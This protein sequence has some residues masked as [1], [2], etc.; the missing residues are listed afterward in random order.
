M[1]KIM[2]SNAK[3]EFLR[4]HVGQQRYPIQLC[5]SPLEIINIGS[6]GNPLIP[7]T[8]KHA[9]RPFYSL[10]SKIGTMLCGPFTR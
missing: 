2:H 8:K 5:R 9:L 4:K 7:D 6:M 10:N 1:F 3:M